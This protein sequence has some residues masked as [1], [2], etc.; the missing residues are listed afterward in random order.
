MSKNDKMSEKAKSLAHVIRRKLYRQRY[1]DVTEI[2]PLFTRQHSRASAFDYKACK[3]QP[4][5]QPQQEKFE[6][7]ELSEAQMR[8]DDDENDPPDLDDS[9][10]INPWKNF[11]SKRPIINW[12]RLPIDL[13]ASCTIPSPRHKDL[14]I[15]TFI[16]CVIWIG[17]CS[18]LIVYVT[19]DVGM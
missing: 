3:A 2:S 10:A 7:I 11:H 8:L 17:I 12:L 9:A 18:Y 14:Y 16:I 13:L 6:K 1:R 4:E 5:Q 15:L 19:T